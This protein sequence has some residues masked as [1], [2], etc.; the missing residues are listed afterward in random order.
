VNL[1]DVAI[2]VAVVSTAT[3]GAVQGLALQLSSVLGLW[4]GLFVGALVA[5]QLTGMTSSP[6]A[7]LFVTILTVAL[8]ASAG[9]GA[10]RAVGLAVG[11]ALSRKRLGPVDAVLGAVVTM[12]ATLGLLWIGLTSVASARLG[13]LTRAIQDSAILAALDRH[14]PPVPAVTARIGRLLDPLGFPT[15]F[16]GL[17]PGP[18]PAVDAPTDPV[19]AAAAAAGREATV[20][21]ESRGCGGLIDGSGVVLGP[22]LVV[23]NAHVIAGVRT[24]VVLDGSTRRPATTLVFDPRVDL[25]V[26]RVPGLAR[27]PL[28]LAADD[29]PGR[30]AAG[31]ALGYPGGGAFTASPAAVRAVYP[32]LGR[33]IYGRSLV[34]RQVAEIQG[35]VR[36]GNSGGPFVLPDGTVAG[37]VFARSISSAG[38]GYALAPSEVR[39]LLDRAATATAAV[40]T[41]ECAAG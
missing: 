40:G 28:T 9:A 1:L 35:E 21:L 22:Q 41:G 36:P 10:G 23:T 13:G 25:A 12:V 14:L 15:V 31:A 2:V 5:P 6:S 26:L 8:A 27:A 32:A 7:K 29:E 11:G 17:E 37:V 34:T 4:L 33:D 16:A 18:A 30:G 3:W 39:P 20:Q 38:I 19:V 24:P